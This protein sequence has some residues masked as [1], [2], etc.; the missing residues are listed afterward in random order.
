MSLAMARKSVGLVILLLVS[1][2][3][4]ANA[5]DS[6]LDGIDDNLDVC[7]YASGNASQ[8]EAF[9]CPDSDGDGWADFQN[10]TAGAW[11]DSV[12]DYHVSPG[13]TVNAVAWHPDGMSYVAGG[14]NNMVERFNVMGQSMGVLL[15][16]PNDVNDLHFSPDGSKLAVAMDNGLMSV[17]DPGNGNNF[18]NFTISSEY[19]I[20]C[21][22]FSHDNSKLFI[23]SQNNTL[24]EINTTNWSQTNSGIWIWSL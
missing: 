5:G 8:A 2:I 13:S 3:S 9:G 14:N 15:A 24:Y 11:Q 7:P 4:T 18:Y 22:Q 1:I 16:G 21:V 20:Y 23:G 10:A 12:Q 19:D 17:I 6:D